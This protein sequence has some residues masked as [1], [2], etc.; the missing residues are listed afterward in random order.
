MPLYEYRCEDGHEIEV[1]RHINDD[2]DVDCP[3]VLEDLGDGTFR[4]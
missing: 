3:E 1:R 4:S 2:S